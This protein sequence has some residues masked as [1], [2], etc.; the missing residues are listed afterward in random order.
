MTKIAVGISFLFV[1]V[2]FALRIY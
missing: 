1:C 2:S